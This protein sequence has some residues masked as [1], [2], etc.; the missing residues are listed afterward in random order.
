MENKFYEEKEVI[1]VLKD[2]AEKLRNFL[3]KIEILNKLYRPSKEGNF[4]FFPLKRNLNEEEINSLKK[5]IKEFIITK[6]NVLKRKNKIKEKLK[7]PLY[8]YPIRYL[9]FNNT[10]IVEIKEEEPLI[11]KEIINY[12]LSIRKK[13]KS[14]YKI[15]NLN[16]LCKG[17]KPNLIYGDKDETIKFSLNGYT[18]MFNINKYIFDIRLF[19]KINEIINKIDKNEIICDIKGNIGVPSIIAANKIG[20]YIYVFENDI[21]LYK[22]LLENIKENNGILKGKIFPIYVQNYEKVN[23]FND[24]FDRILILEPNISYSLLTLVCKMII[25]KNVTINML[26]FSKEREPFEDVFVKIRDIVLNSGKKIENFFVKKI[27][28]ITLQETLVECNFKII[29]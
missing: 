4:V 6:K 10:I 5:I 16:L 23:Y 11:E 29:S 18:F 25:K 2:E 17:I 12:I 13:C 9:S 28:N 1:G 21:E 15:K 20:S 26:A 14:I 27:M 3:N 24:K 22:N 8:G 7:Y 19:W